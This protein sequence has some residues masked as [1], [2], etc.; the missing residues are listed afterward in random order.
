MFYQM[1]CTSGF[2]FIDPLF[3]LLYI[4]DLP[5]ATKLAECSLFA[6]DAS[7][8]LSHSDLSYLI[9]TMNVEL[10]NINVWMKIN[11][12]S[13][14]T[15]KTNYI[16]FRPKQKSITLNMSVLFNSKPL[17]RV[18]VVKF[19][20]IFIDEKLHGSFI[21]IMSALK[22]PSLSELFLEHVLFCLLTYLNLSLY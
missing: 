14:S 7:I 18:N 12:L 5:N 22:F 8:F 17:K 4:N 2:N 15:G 19:L 10:E 20:G 9:S 11:K 16:I 1:W 13:V 6:D 3:Y 21:S